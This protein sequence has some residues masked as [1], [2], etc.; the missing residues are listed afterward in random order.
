MKYRQPTNNKRQN[1]TPSNYSAWKGKNPI[2]TPGKLR[3]HL[4]T[5][6]K[7][8]LATIPPYLCAL[9]SIQD[10]NNSVVPGIIRSVVMEEM[11]HLS[12]A[13]NLLNA[14]GGKPVIDHTTM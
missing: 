14:V 12:M 3:Q 10:G 4:Q 6:I 7:I 9:W 13:A 11:L 2:D 5:A 8:E 1:L